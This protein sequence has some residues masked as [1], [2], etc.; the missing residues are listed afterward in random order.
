L[1]PDLEIDY[2]E[3]GGRNNWEKFP[4]NCGKFRNSRMGTW[5]NFGAQ[6][7][8]ENNFYT[9]RNLLKMPIFYAMI[10]SPMNF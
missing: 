3:Y 6:E 4:E 1:F 8:E 10:C 5:V 7:I 2:G 9:S